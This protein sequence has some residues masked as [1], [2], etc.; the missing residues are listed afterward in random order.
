MACRGLLKI[1]SRIN[2][3]DEK[4]GKTKERIEMASCLKRMLSY[5]RN[6]FIIWALRKR[7]CG[8][9]RMLSA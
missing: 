2:V 5:E 6:P 1:Q 8:F 3:V 9:G 7:D 4:A